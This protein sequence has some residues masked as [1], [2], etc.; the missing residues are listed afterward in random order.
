MIIDESKNVV[1]VLMNGLEIMCQFL[2]R[3]VC[4]CVQK[5]Y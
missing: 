4:L 5:Y 2:Y 1:L 3:S